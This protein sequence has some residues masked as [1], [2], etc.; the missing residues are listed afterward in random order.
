[1]HLP[2]AMWWPMVPARTPGG[3]A[4]YLLLIRAVG[5][6]F[7]HIVLLL[8]TV[9][10]LNNPSR[11]FVKSMRPVLPGSSS[12]KASFWHISAANNQTIWIESTR[13]IVPIVHV[14]YHIG[15]KRLTK[16]TQGLAALFTTCQQKRGFV[17]AKMYG[18]FFSLGRLRSRNPCQLVGVKY[19]L[20]ID[21]FFLNL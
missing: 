19:L 16:G 9:I 2:V 1:M 10:G 8:Q 13:S 4:E 15:Y 17:C 14:D 11:R 18:V 20:I 3:W 6:L 7:I 21:F 5:I 12:W